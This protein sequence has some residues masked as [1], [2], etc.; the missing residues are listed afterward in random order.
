M[1]LLAKFT[2]SII[3]LLTE[4]SAFADAQTKYRLSQ[5][6]SLSHRTSVPV[7]M[8]N[9]GERSQWDARQSAYASR[10]SFT[11]LRDLVYGRHNRRSTFPTSLFSFLFRKL[12]PQTK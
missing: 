8:R 2:M 1:F 9:L 4:M 3:A 6:K 5:W 7:A 10:Y 12:A 11:F